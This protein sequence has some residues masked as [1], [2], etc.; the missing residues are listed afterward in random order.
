[1]RGL[2]CWLGYQDLN[3][4]MARSKPAALPLGDIPTKEKWLGYQD[5]N[6]GMARSKP[7]ALPLGDIPTET[8]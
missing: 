3:L 4:G 1:M 2:E 5:L 6:L 7:A 8:F